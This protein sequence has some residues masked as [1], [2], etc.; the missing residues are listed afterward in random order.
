MNT[1]QV[2]GGNGQS[3]AGQPQVISHPNDVANLVLMQID[4]VNARKDELTIAMK[5]LTDTAK[6]LV[7][8][9]SEHTG[10]IIALRQKLDELEKQN[11]TRQ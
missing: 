10:T 2:R 3:T 7:R 5:N 4:A 9:Y 6:Q 1:E 8:A 11:A